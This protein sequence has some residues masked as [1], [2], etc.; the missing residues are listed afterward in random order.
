MTDVETIRASAGRQESMSVCALTDHE[1]VQIEG[2]D[3]R[4]FLQGQVSCDV[5]LLSDTRSLPG[6]I[7]NLKG[8]V[9]ADFQLLQYGD[10]CLLRTAGGMADTIVKT[11]ARYAVF[12]KV[13]LRQ[14]EPALVLGLIGGGFEA[15]LSKLFPRLPMTA[16]ECVVS[17]QMCLLR[18]PGER[19][20]LWC[21]DATAVSPL[22]ELFGEWLPNPGREWLAAAIEAGD[23]HVRPASSEAYTPQLLN[24]DLSGVVN[25]SKGCYTGQEVVAR[26]HF[27]GTPKKRLFLFRGEAEFSA[28]SRV[29]A[30]A[31]T[32]PGKGEPVL[33]HVNRESAASLALAVADIKTVAAGGAW[34]LNGRAEAPLR[35]APLAYPHAGAKA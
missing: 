19:M 34:F 3:A 11:L 35:A 5:Q 26:M 10:A 12:S 16:H 6:A 33:A 21:M 20:E 7:C 4:V 32:E 9:I 17:S 25:F 23:V 28:D 24:Y 2:P 30:A 8:R 1:F 14:V 18:L 22:R 31:Q 27:R 15:A 13:E 29:C